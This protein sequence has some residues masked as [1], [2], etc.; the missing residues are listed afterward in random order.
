MATLIDKDRMRLII[1]N[2][3]F[4][5]ILLKHKIQ[6]RSDIKTACIDGVNL[7]YNPIWY[8]NLNPDQRVTIL[9]HEVL[10]I[11]NMHH[12]RSEGRQHMYW[13]VAC[14]YAINPFLKVSPHQLP[15][16]CLYDAKYDGM[17]SEEIYSKLLQDSQEDKQEQEDDDQQDDDDDSGD[18]DAPSSGGG[19]GDTP[20]DDLYD[21]S[22]GDVAP[23]PNPDGMTKSELESETKIMVK[24]AMTVAKAAGK[25]PSDI[26]A[27]FNKLL[28][29]KV[30]W[31]SII[32]RW[33][34]GFSNNDYSWSRPNPIHLK[35]RIILPSLQS[36]AFADI[37]VAIDTSGS[38]SDKVLQQAVSEVFAGLSVYTENNQDDATIKVIYCDS[39]IN[40]VDIIEHEGQV[41][42][43]CG[44]GGTLFTPVFDHIKS[45]PP[46]G[47]V[48]IT[49]GYGWDFPDSVNTD[50]IWL[51]TKC[52]DSHFKPPFGE[53]IH[54]T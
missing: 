4:A 27:H 36:D 47:L 35:N 30:D 28:Q 42:K 46:A 6:E 32:S 25:M 13:N 41:T 29:P 17:S 5:T 23:H 21:Q 3:F 12:L 50:V 11:T 54:M 15:D 37:N 2:P 9:C 48:Y 51:I 38:M 22:V 18:N 1:N 20:I 8:N 52:G 16:G 7:Y 33:I 53:V 49:D 26:E 45:N 31:K 44:R 39:E 14:D 34:E 10:H 19:G 24:Q 40:K 43:P